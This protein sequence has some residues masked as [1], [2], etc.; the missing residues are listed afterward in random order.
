MRPRATSIG[1][2]GDAQPDPRLYAGSWRAPLQRTIGKVVRKSAVE[3]I[4]ENIDTV[5]VTPEKLEKFLGAPRFHYEKAGKKPEVGVVNGL[6]YTVVGGDTL[7]IETTIMPGTGV[8][9]LTAV[10]AT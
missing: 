7:Q 2:N 4:D 1:D 9:E 6:A 5:T 10:S 3:M 8:L